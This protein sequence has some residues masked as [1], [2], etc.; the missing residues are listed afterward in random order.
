MTFRDMRFSGD[1][2]NWGRFFF[3]W[4]PLRLPRQE[5]FHGQKEGHASGVHH[6]GVQMSKVTGGASLRYAAW[7]R[8]VPQF[9]GW[10]AVGFPAFGSLGRICSCS[11]RLELLDLISD[12]ILPDTYSLDWRNLFADLLDTFS[13]FIVYV[14][15][16]CAHDQSVLSLPSGQ[17]TRRDSLSRIQ[18]TWWFPAIRFLSFLAF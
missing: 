17:Y 8:G 10:W 2:S 4:H 7:S 12:L 1:P 3:S 14:G 18:L 6:R 13:H 16:V 15:Q 5:V 9:F 11:T